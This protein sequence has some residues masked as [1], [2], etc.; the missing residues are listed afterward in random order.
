MCLGRLRVIARIQCRKGGVE[1]RMGIELVQIVI[2]LGWGL[3]L[4][5][6]EGELVGEVVSVSRGMLLLL[7]LLLLLTVVRGR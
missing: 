3:G 4:R 2:L 6:A 7:L 5:W 1:M